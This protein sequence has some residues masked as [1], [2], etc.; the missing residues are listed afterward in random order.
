M[1][2]RVDGVSKEP[3]VKVKSYTLSLVLTTCGK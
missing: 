2:F 3:E 1:L